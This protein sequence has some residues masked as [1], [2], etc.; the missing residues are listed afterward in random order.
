MRTRLLHAFSCIIY[1]GE[2]K[3]VE[4]SK[5]FKSNKQATFANFAG[6]EEYIHQWEQKRLDLEDSETWSQ[7]Y[8]PATMIY[9]SKGV[10]EGKVLFRSVD[11]KLILSNEPLLGCGRLPEWLANKKCIYA[12][13]K[14]N[15]NLCVWRCLAVHQRITKKQKRSEEDTNRHALRLARDFY[16]RPKLKTQEI[17]PTRII[18]FDKIAKHFGI[19]IR[20]F[21]PKKILK[22][23]GSWFMV[24]AK[25]PR[26]INRVLISVYMTAIVFISKTLSY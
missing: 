3:I 6:I 7:A 13:D 25:P 23:F 10:Y 21:E 4:Y 14:I 9:D 1:R 5:T 17:S 19:N 2:G 24:K 18:D 16:A 12:I 8:L 11:I 20:L 22:K 15:D 26:L